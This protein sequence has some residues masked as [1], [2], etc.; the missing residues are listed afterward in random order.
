MVYER[1][2]IMICIVL[3]FIMNVIKLYLKIHVKFWINI[4]TDNAIR[5]LFYDKMYM[6][7]HE[8]KIS[9]IDINLYQIMISCCSGTLLCCMCYLLEI[10]LYIYN[11]YIIYIYNIIIYNTLLILSILLR[12]MLHRMHL[13]IL[14]KIF[15][16]DICIYYILVCLCYII[17]I[18]AIN[19]CCPDMLSIYVLYYKQF[20]ICYMHYY[21]LKF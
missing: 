11:I 12:Y 14:R 3:C 19:I 17:P 13:L 21:N 16:Y 6:V 2:K 7:M 5:S 15:I 20:L 9:V 8:C 1:C 18:Y 10:F 4:L